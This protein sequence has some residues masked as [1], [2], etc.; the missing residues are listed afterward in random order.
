MAKRART[1][2]MGTAAK[3][4]G[5]DDRRGTAAQRGYGHKWRRESKAWLDRHPFC[6]DCDRAG[7]IRL[8]SLVDHI[9]PHRGNMK[10]FWDRGNWQSLCKTCHGVKTGRGE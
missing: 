1:L 7:R 2:R 6:A 10:L 5:C 9:V 8:A 3:V 4:I